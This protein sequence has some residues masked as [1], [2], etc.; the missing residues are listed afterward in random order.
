MSGTSSWIVHRCSHLQLYNTSYMPITGGTFHYGSIGVPWRLHI[1]LATSGYHH[2]IVYVCP[3]TGYRLESLIHRFPRCKHFA[4]ETEVQEDNR[5]DGKPVEV[6]TMSNSIISADIDSTG[7]VVCPVT[8]SSDSNVE[9]VDDH[10]EGEICEPSEGPA[11]AVKDRTVKEWEMVHG[12]MYGTHKND[13]IPKSLS[14]CT[15]DE[16]LRFRFGVIL[17]PPLSPSPAQPSITSEERRNFQN[18]ERM[19]GVLF[20]RL[21]QC[22]RRL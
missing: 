1:K 6:I 8:V 4:P 9:L 20:C 16:T 21:I 2:I 12:R 11:P 7:C 14:V 17:V 13:L 18:C 15:L 10:E 22:W 3:R 19:R 5:I